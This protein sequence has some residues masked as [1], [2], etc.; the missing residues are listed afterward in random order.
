M[1]FGC[2]ATRIYTFAPSGV[3]APDGCAG[4]C[5]CDR[6]LQQLLLRFNRL[7]QSLD[8]FFLCAIFSR[9]FRDLLECLE[10]LR[11]EPLELPGGDAVSGVWPIPSCT[12][13]KQR[14]RTHS[15][16]SSIHN[17][18]QELGLTVLEAIADTLTRSLQTLKTPL[19]YR[20]TVT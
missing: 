11:P 8:L 9:S 12:P 20:T 5:G 10:R 3:A 6:L 2:A 17:L 4:F 14:Q 7:L 19:S 15:D 16:Q 18:L 13:D 1:R